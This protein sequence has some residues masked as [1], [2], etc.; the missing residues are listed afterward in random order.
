MQRISFTN[1]VNLLLKASILNI[2]LY[3]SYTCLS[4]CNQKILKGFNMN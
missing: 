2:K 1:N 3:F 4:V